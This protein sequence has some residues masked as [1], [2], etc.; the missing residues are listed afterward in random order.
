[1]SSCLGWL[2]FLLGK[3]LLKLTCIGVILQLNH[4]LRQA[5]SW[6]GKAKHKRCL[7]KEALEFKGFFFRALWLLRGQG[8][9]GKESLL[10]MLQKAISSY[11]KGR[12]S[13]SLQ[14]MQS[15]LK[16]AKQIGS[17]LTVCIY[18][19]KTT[20]IIPI[21][22][23]GLLKY[24]KPQ[25]WKVNFVVNQCYHNSKSQY[26]PVSNT[27]LSTGVIWSQFKEGYHFRGFSGKRKRW[28]ASITLWI[29]I[30]N[31]QSVIN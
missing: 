26:L 16:L 9:V 6:P 7:P 23:F 3:C 8:L 24:L 27:K 11:N 25:V 31:N 12:N 18:G 19:I 30:Y 14:E 2:V 29:N 21:L 22:R 20:I 28:V 15:K 4:Y 17:G 5:S 13:M 1:M 10:F